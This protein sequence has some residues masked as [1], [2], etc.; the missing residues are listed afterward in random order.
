VIDLCGGE[1]GAG[2]V[3]SVDGRRARA[4]QS[5]ACAEANGVQSREDGVTILVINEMDA[6]GV[7]D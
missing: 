2:M 1:F 6:P 4:R 3:A 5:D 7:E